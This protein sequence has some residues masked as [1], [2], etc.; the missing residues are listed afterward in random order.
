MPDL[1]N[2]LL[3]LLD[4]L[5]DVDWLIILLLHYYPDLA[6]AKAAVTAEAARRGLGKCGSYHIPQN[7]W[8]KYVPRGLME[9]IRGFTGSDAHPVRPL[10]HMTRIMLHTLHD[11]LFLRKAPK[12]MADNLN[13]FL[14]PKNEAKCALIV[15]SRG[16][17]RLNSHRR[18]K[19]SLPNLC[20]IYALI[21]SFPPGTL[22]GFTVDLSNFFWSLKMPK[23]ATDA[24]RVGGYSFPCLPFGWDLSPV[25]AQH[26]LGDLIQEAIKCHHLTQYNHKSLFVFHYYDDIFGICTSQALCQTFSNKLTAFL[27][28]KNLEI[29]PKSHLEPGQHHVWI[30]KHFD[31]QNC[32]IRNTRTVLLHTLAM[33]LAASWSPVHKKVA[34]RVTGFALWA[35]RPHRGATLSLRGWYIAQLHRDR[36]MKHPSLGMTRGIM[37]SFS[38]SCVDYRLPPTPP[39]PF[40]THVVCGDAAQHAKGYHVGLFSPTFG[41]RIIRC[42]PQVVTQQAAELFAVDAATRLATRLGWTQ[43]TYVGDNTAALAITTNLR[44]PLYNA[45]MTNIT[46][47]IRNRLLWT[48]SQVHLVWVPSFLQPADPPSRANPLCTTEHVDRE[49]AERWDLL[50]QC[51]NLARYFGLLSH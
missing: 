21:N 29:S 34:E 31:L 49:A 2:T 13:I 51:L 17:N 4:L 15:D 16:I 26:S 28:A 5:P 48:N 33:T 12:G 47:R 44:P 25:L 37:D 36:Y 43:Y 38:I 50:T 35:A 27:K 42:P 19:F 45:V 32:C 41:S 23:E 24:F 22:W 46:R 30:G 9:K 7:I 6:G 8:D 3:D 14:K 10:K 11:Q 18:P 20:D 1:W 40:T 39:L